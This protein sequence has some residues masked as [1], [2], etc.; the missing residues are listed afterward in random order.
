V[1]ET[2]GTILTFLATKNATTTSH[3]LL[4]TFFVHTIQKHTNNIYTPSPTQT[5]LLEIWKATKRILNQ[6][7]TNPRIKYPD[8]SFSKTNSENPTY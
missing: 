2:A 4:K 3:A 5:T 6:K 7:N 1:P 8:G